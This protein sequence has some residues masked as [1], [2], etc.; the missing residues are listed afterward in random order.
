MMSIAI[1]PAQETEVTIGLLRRF[2]PRAAEG[3]VSFRLWEGT[4]WPDERSRSATI[5]LHHPDAVRA[6][7]SAGTE[8]GVAEAFLRDDFDVEGAIETACELAD[9][10]ADRGEGGWFHTARTLFQLRAAGAMRPQSARAWSSPAPWQA[11]RHSRAR[12]REAIAFHY[13]LSND[14]FRLWLDARMIYSCAYFENSD[15][16]L[17]TA[18]TAKLH[19]LCRKLRLQPGQRVLD[20]GCGWGGF[21]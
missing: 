11:R 3:N 13:D 16:D 20:I 21:P 15:D 2:F 7:F 19:H 14:F 6:M 10:L 8:K 4:M 17:E 1:A 18:Q 12:D 9:S 5:I